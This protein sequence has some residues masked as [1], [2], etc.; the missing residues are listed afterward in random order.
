M[1]HAVRTDV[2]WLVEE[3]L[4][5]RDPALAHLEMWQSGAGRA[6]CCLD[7]ADTGYGRQ[8]SP[9]HHPHLAS[10]E[11]LRGVARQYGLGLLPRR[12]RART[13]PHRPARCAKRLIE[14]N[15]ERLRIDDPYCHG[16]A[17]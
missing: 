3:L 7:A 15:P 12:P 8:A 9:T 16:E 17:G 2:E 6:P 14:R 11:A 13:A 1:H 4:H 10:A 5:H